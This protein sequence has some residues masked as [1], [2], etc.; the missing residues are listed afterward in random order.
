MVFAIFTTP[1]I[2]EKEKLMIERISVP[3]DYLM[4][5]EPVNPILLEVP[6]AFIPFVYEEPDNS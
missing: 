2:E 1:M 6:E 4:D 3:D 5:C